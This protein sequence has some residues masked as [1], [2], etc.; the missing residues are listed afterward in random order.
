MCFLSADGCCCCYYWPTVNYL[1]NCL[2]SICWIQPFA[3][4]QLL[5]FLFLWPFFFLHVSWSFFSSIHLFW[6]LP[7]WFLALNIP[8]SLP[9]Q[10]PCS[11]HHFFYPPTQCGCF[12]DLELYSWSWH[13]LTKPSP[14]VWTKSRNM[15]W[16][17][18]MFTNILTAERFD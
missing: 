3:L 14:K 4:I 7:S 15:L 13:K 6:Y 17:H 1:P 8:R 10:P 9:F 12:S 2:K 18:R 5:P 16:C 11:T